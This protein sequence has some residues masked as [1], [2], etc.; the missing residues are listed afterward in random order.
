MS[1][2]RRLDRKKVGSSINHTPVLTASAL[3]LA[4]PQMPRSMCVGLLKSYGVVI[5]DADITREVVWHHV[6][7]PR[8]GPNGTPIAHRDILLVRGD[9]DTVTHFIWAN[10]TRGVYTSTSHGIDY[11]TYTTFQTIINLRRVDLTQTIGLPI[12]TM[13]PRIFDV[14]VDVC[15]GALR[16]TF[17]D[18]SGEWVYT[19]KINT[20][21]TGH[22]GK[23]EI[24]PDPTQI[25]FRMWHELWRYGTLKV[26][27]ATLSTVLTV[28]TPKGDRF[29][30][31]TNIT[32]KN[33]LVAQCGRDTTDTIDDI[34]WVKTVYE[35]VLVI[36]AAV[37]DVKL[38]KVLIST[39]AFT[40]VGKQLCVRLSAFTTPSRMMRFGAVF[41]ATLLSHVMFTES[42]RIRLGSIEIVS[43]IAAKISAGHLPVDEIGRMISRVERK[44]SVVWSGDGVNWKSAP[45]CMHKGME[46]GFHYRHRWPVSYTVAF[47]ARLTSTEPQSIAQ[48]IIDA[49]K[50]SPHVTLDRTSKF[51]T[52]LKSTLQTNKPE[53]KCM[54]FKSV[55]ETTSLGCPF[56]DSHPGSSVENCMASR[57]MKSGVT[58]DPRQVTPSQMWVLSHPAV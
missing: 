48:H 4:L 53:F 10:R 9:D 44:R 46:A 16:Q 58:L 24:V 31:D 38:A 23:L 30:T 39:K 45:L 22:V 51:K 57:T 33:T 3:G 43:E 11:Y 8:T 36:D 54:M 49:I 14:G 27:T 5:I 18:I 7:D 35:P 32:V 13:T 2:R 41:N 1:K 26:E 20:I 15:M 12:F 19:D 37:F 25:L 28:Q 29:Y 40:T 55:A 17:G 6:S 21:I 42:Q 47:A 52:I 50:V 34:S 56:K